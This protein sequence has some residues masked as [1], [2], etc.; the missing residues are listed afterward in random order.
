[1][2][3]KLA[4][5]PD[6][7]AGSPKTTDH[8]TSPTPGTPSPVYRAMHSVEL[9]FVSADDECS[10]AAAARPSACGPCDVLAD[11]V[12]QVLCNTSKHAESRQPSFLHLHAVSSNLFRA[13]LQQTSDPRALEHPRDYQAISPVDTSLALPGRQETSD[14]VSHDALLAEVRLR[15]VGARRQ[16]AHKIQSEF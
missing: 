9:T 2:S 13:M 11:I 1:M 12:G 3:K 16:R 15:H 7:N 10:E 4:N 8:S 14:S 5:M 6:A